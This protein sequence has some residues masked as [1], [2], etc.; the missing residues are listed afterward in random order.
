[1]EYVRDGFAEPAGPTNCLIQDRFDRPTEER[2]R[3]G[4]TVVGLGQAPSYLS[5]ATPA[6]CL[7]G[8]SLL[9]NL[10]AMLLPPCISSPAAD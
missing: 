9:L 10:S 5:F 3:K 7:C 1:M 2:R 4:E 6:I 8:V